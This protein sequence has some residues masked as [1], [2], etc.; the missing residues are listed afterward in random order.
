M[1]PDNKID[2]IRK[3]YSEHFVLDAEEAVTCH[4]LLNTSAI[5]DQI[6]IEVA[7]RCLFEKG[8]TVDLFFDAYVALTDVLEFDTANTSGDSVEVT[9]LVIVV[10]GNNYHLFSQVDAIMVLMALSP[11]FERLSEY[12]VKHGGEIDN[13]SLASSTVH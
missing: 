6:I 3:A 8:L 11:E 9:A 4:F 2:I 10:N 5:E 7:L 13:Q 12:M 1:S